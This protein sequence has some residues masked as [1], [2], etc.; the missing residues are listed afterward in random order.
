ME[1]AKATLF[2]AHERESIVRALIDLTAENGYAGTTIEMVLVHAGVDREAF[3]RHFRNRSDCFFSVWDEVSQEWIENL[4]E[5]FR[6]EDR[7][8]DGLR[9]MLYRAVSIAG[10]DPNRAAFEIEVLAAGQGA[11]A[12]RDMTL[13]CFAALIDEGRLAMRDHQLIPHTT[14]EALAGSA[15][16]QI[17][18]KIAAGAHSEL[19]SLVPELAA[20]I[21]LPYL[22]SA[23]LAEV[24]V[25][26]TAIEGDGQAVKAT[27]TGSSLAGTSLGAFAY[28]GNRERLIAGLAVAVQRYGYGGASISRVAGSAALSPRTFYRYFT[29]KTACMDAA[30]ATVI[31]EM[32]E[33]AETAFEAKGRWPSGLPAALSAMLGF[34]ADEPALAHLCLVEALGAGRVG[35]QTSEVAIQSF[36]PM[37]NVGDTAQ[38]TMDAGARAPSPR[39]EE[40]IA[41]GVISVITHR[42]KD[43]GTKALTGLLPELTVFAL[44]PYLGLA[45]AEWLVTA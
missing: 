1:V 34:L 36:A 10:S 27:R 13:R 12:R 6:V 11:R 15:Y 9:A 23:A 2:G 14:A 8:L 37:F 19:L 7:W 44:A 33:R 18:A 3:E 45:K 5:A 43:E 39:A 29:S 41:A 21:A 35:R 38:F 42:L 40:L 26:P 22:G 17:Q 28:R 20:S 30:F 24:T 4:T 32:R 31:A 16:C 25:E